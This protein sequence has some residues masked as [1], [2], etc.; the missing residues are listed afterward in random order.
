MSEVTMTA[1]I[2]IDL[3]RSEGGISVTYEHPDDY[4]PP[5]L[6]TELVRIIKDHT[7]HQPDPLAHLHPLPSE[8]SP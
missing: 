5:G 6:I 1:R 7:D 8:T 4:I 2:Q 3:T